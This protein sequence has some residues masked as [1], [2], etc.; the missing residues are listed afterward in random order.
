MGI[1]EVKFW[2]CLQL[3]GEPAA[4]NIASVLHISLPSCTSATLQTVENHLSTLELLETC[5]VSK[6]QNTTSGALWSFLASS[7]SSGFL[8]PFPLVGETWIKG[9]FLQA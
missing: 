1:I 9:P 7:L 6:G 5:Y 8:R 3:K 2:L 4:K